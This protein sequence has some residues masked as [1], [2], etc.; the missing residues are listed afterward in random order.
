MAEHEYPLSIVAK[1][2]NKIISDIV[3]D[4][5]TELNPKVDKITEDIAND[6]AKQLAQVTPRSSAN[7]D[8]LADSVKVSTLKA[9]SYGKSSKV[10]VVHYKKWQIAHLLEFGWTTKNGIKINRQPFVRPLFDQ[11][12][13]K[14]VKMYKDGLDK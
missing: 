14:Y 12:K 7:T 5:E 2:M 11:N 8:H 3:Q 10:Y 9:K 6:F 1:E 4:Y 13:E